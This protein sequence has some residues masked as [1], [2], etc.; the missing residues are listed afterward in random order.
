MLRK[1]KI[2]EHKLKI[3]GRINLTALEI[4]RF[5]VSLQPRKELSLA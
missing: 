4:R 2:S 1:D 3:K 5:V